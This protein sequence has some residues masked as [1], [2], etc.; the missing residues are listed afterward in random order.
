MAVSRAVSAFPGKDVSITKPPPSRLYAVGSN[1][2]SFAMR[3]LHDTKDTF[4]MVCISFLEALDMLQTKLRLPTSLVKE[5][6]RRLSKMVD[7]SIT[8]PVSAPMHDK[9]QRAQSLGEV[10]AESDAWNEVAKPEEVKGFVHWLLAVMKWLNELALAGTVGTCRRIFILVMRF[11]G[12]PT[13]CAL[14]CRIFDTVERTVLYA[15]GYSALHS[16]SDSSANTNSVATPTRNAKRAR[17]SQYMDD[18]SLTA[19]VLEYREKECMVPV[20]INRRIQQF[21]HFEIP[22]RSFEA[23]VRLP[24]SAENRSNM[25]S[26]QPGDLVRSAS[27]RGGGGGEAEQ[28]T[29]GDG[30]SSSSSAGPSSSSP[31][32]IPASPRERR[33]FNLI[34]GNYFDDVLYQARDK[35]RLQRA[36]SLTGETNRQIPRFNKSECDQ[37]VHLTCGRNCAVKEGP[38]MYRSVRGTVPIL[39]NRHVYFEMKLSSDALPVPLNGIV[40]DENVNACIGIAPRSMPLNTLVG[41]ARN[42]IGF[43]SAGHVLVS[44]LYRRLVT[45]ESGF[46][47]P[48]TIGVLVYITDKRKSDRDLDTY[49][50]VGMARADVQFSVNGVPVRDLEGNFLVASVEFSAKFELYPTLSLH[51][52]GLRVYAQFSSPDIAAFNPQC[53]L[54]SEDDAENVVCLD[55]LRVPVL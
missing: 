21:M 14:F 34:Y 47:C 3:S 53:F 26:I 19:V 30:A 36:V 48:S 24:S 10:V 31:R 17:T 8:R 37:E 52:Q 33:K 44:G 43:T 41:T 29:A 7:H 22:L 13:S 28:S 5:L 39:R 50:A 20:N 6:K 25:A 23:T 11:P 16:G 42:S 51:T 54:L 49:H 38:G 40:P 2:R 55:G 32:S 46:A 12:V 18:S 35:L 45:V 4:L 15:L 27:R 9:I 1:A